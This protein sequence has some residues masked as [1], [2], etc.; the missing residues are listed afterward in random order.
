MTLY[1]VTYLNSPL[2]RSEAQKRNLLLKSIHPTY[3]LAFSASSV[4]GLSASLILDAF[5]NSC[6]PLE[7]NAFE[8]HSTKYVSMKACVKP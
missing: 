1:I 7:V 4:D 2:G 3:V 5:L 6:S 8:C